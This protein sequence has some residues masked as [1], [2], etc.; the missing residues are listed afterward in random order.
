MIDLSKNPFVSIITTAGL[1][2][3]LID[4]L[5]V[6]GLQWAA[7]DSA[8]A[9]WFDRVKLL[10]FQDNTLVFKYND[11]PG[12]KYL[13]SAF[14]P[15]IGMSSLP[16]D[17]YY[18]GVNAGSINDCTQWD[19]RQA[20]NSGNLPLDDDTVFCK[21]EMAAVYV[22]NNEHRV[23]S[24]LYNTYSTEAQNRQPPDPLHLFDVNKAILRES[25][26][27]K[28]VSGETMEFTTIMY[29]ETKEWLKLANVT[30]SITTKEGISPSQAI[31]DRHT[32]GQA[33]IWALK[34]YKGPD[35]FDSYAAAFEL[36]PWLDSGDKLGFSEALRDRPM[37][38]LGIVPKQIFSFP[39]QKVKAKWTQESVR[40]YCLE[41]SAKSPLISDTVP[42][43][44]NDPQSGTSQTLKQT[45]DGED[46][47]LY[48]DNWWWWVLHFV[49]LP[50]Q[51]Y[52]VLII[53]QMVGFVIYTTFS[54]PD[55]ALRDRTKFSEAK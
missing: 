17:T 3:A 13:L 31:T 4:D 30:V 35:S 27:L 37:M 22:M 7:L 18:L 42:P 26:V 34:N 2:L 19:M 50:V 51:S 54:N 36:L 12:V 49:V 52:I 53:C 6:S 46:G 47:Q 23:E 45:F 41:R 48:A 11:Q 32:K 15:E 1:Q 28:H 55:P 14:H 38:K 8:A 9:F 44:F 20:S 29:G 5:Q 33:L 39:N 40:A 10:G 24:V 21:L 16:P 25:A 43:T